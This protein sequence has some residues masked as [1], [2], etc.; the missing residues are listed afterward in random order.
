MIASK[1]AT[2]SADPSASRSADPSASRSADPSASRSAV[3]VPAAAR[4]LAEASISANTRRAYGSALARLDAWLDGRPLDDAA[5]S[6]YLA[7]MFAV[8]RS[9]ATAGQTAAAIRFRAKLTGQGDPIGPAS[10][11]VLAGFRREGN[12]RG[13]G[14]VTGMRWEQ[15][16]ATAAVA[17]NGGGAIAGLRDAAIV[18]IMSD[19]MLRVSECAALDVVDLATE[20]DGTGRLTIRSSKTDQA[21]EGAVQYIGA[22]TVRRVRAWLEAAGI[23]DDA[24]F[25]SIRRGDHPTG[26]RITPRAIRTIIAKRAAEAGV[27]GRV[28]GHSLRVG[29][30]QSLAAAGAGLVEMQTAGRWNS[31]D[32][33]GRYAAGQLAARGA[34]ARL[35]YNA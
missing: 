24:M 10:A 23:T 28:S 20:A 17:A 12:G 33:P 30:A 5:L 27:E 18:A 16:D 1:I 26:K 34:V 3:I 14:Q 21:G 13:R 6:T 2:R 35:R 4:H 11:R 31:P 29:S 8:G 9:P 25:Q 22:P 32:M 7:E 15:A 19:A